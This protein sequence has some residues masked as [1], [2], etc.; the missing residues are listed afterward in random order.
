MSEKFKLKDFFLLLNVL[1]H[2]AVITVYYVALVL[3]V[4]MFKMLNVVSITMESNVELLLS[5][6]ALAGLLSLIVTLF[7]KIVS[8]VIG[9][10][11]LIFE[12]RRRLVK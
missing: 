11:Y 10:H 1:F 9:L 7:G 8:W 4:T 12:N 3:S 5:I 2:S 6:I